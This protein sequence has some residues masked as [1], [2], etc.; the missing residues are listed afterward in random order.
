MNVSSGF[1]GIVTSE[2]E[3]DFIKVDLF[4][5]EAM[6]RDQACAY[7]ELWDY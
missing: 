4:E 1:S 5:W 7:D 3:S 2:F 6:W